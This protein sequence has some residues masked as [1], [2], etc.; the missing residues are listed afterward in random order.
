MTALSHLNLSNNSIARISPELGLMHPTLRMLSL[1]GNPLR[2][3]RQAVL[4]K[5]TPA[6]LQYLREM[7]KP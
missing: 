4:Q 2:N 7:R 6:V 5:G 3:P 1:E